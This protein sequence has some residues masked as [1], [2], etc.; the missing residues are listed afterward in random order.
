MKEATEAVR[1]EA[2]KLIGVAI[3]CIQKRWIKG[4][5]DDGRGGVCALGAITRGTIETKT[6]IEASNLTRC[7]VEQEAK[8][9]DIVHYYPN[10]IQVQTIATWNDNKDTT[11]ENVLA[12]FRSAKKILVKSL[13]PERESH[14]PATKAHRGR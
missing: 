7:L 14:D 12:G 13:P 1:R 5:L 10:R 11:K 2:L 8:K 3:K 9:A 4:R 6:S